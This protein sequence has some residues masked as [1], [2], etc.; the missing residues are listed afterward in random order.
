MAVGERISSVFNG[1][2]DKDAYFEVALVPKER[3]IK[4]PS[5]AKRK[6]LENLYA[7][8]RKIRVRGNL[9]GAFFWNQCHLVVSVLI[10][11]AVKDRADSFSNRHVVKAPVRLEQHPVAIFRAAVYKRDQ[12]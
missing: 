6:R 8:V 12:Q 9:D 1:A 5:D 3:T 10:S 2:A 4:V 11:S 7:Q